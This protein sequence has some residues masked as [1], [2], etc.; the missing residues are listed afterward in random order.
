MGSSAEN[1]VEVRQPI[2]T[3][4]LQAYLTHALPDGVQ[5]FGGGRLEVKQFDNGAS[6]PT[7]F[8]QSPAGEKYVLRKK[9]PGKLLPGAHQVD[10]EFR[11]QK[12]LAGTGVPV[13]EVLLLCQDPAV[14]GQD[15]YLMKFVKG[16]IFNDIGRK[17]EWGEGARLEGFCE[18]DRTALHK[19]IIRVLAKLHSVEYKQVGLEGFGKV[20]D[21]VQR[22]VRTWSRNMVAQDA[23]VTKASLEDSFVWKAARM[24]ELTQKLEKMGKNIVE[25]T[26]IT[27]GDYRLGNLMIHPEEPR[28]VA[29]LDWELCTLGH[30][31]A[32]LAWLMKPWN[33]SKGFYNADGSDP[34]GVP[35]QEALL[36]L[37]VRS[38]G[39]SDIPPHEWDFFRALDCFRTA[40]INHGVYARAVMGTA[41]TSIARVAGKTLDF[42]TE[43]GLAFA[44]SAEQALPTTSSRL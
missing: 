32:D 20:G 2:N 7:Y 4:K 14:L 29:V 38:R 11:V 17:G 26:V 39:V 13:P 21:Y 37:Y 10:R 33:S 1:V 36:Q 8:I 18:S 43:R 28:V 5:T 27:H 41:A 15:F 44:T 42:F 12:A 9:P 24:Q 16:R 19:D 35:T 6:N 25:P 23:I 31:L 40:G 22:Q 30:P 34:E 3:D